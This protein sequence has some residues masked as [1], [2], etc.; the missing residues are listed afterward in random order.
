MAKIKSYVDLYT[1]TKLQLQD[2][3][4]GT[5]TVTIIAPTLAQDWALTL[6]PDDGTSGQYL[7]TDGSGVTTWQTISGVQDSPLDLKNYSIATS[8]SSNALTIALKDKAGSDPS[9]GSPVNIAV[10]SATATSG[11]YNIR[12]VTGALSL[13]ISSGSTLG[14]IDGK[15]AYIYVYVLDN[16]G[17]LELVAS[18]TRYD[19][20]SIQTTTAE[21]GSGAADS[22]TG[23]YSTSAR[24]NVPV[25]F[26]GR[27]ASVQTTAGTWAAQMQEVSIASQAANTDTYGRLNFVPASGAF[28]T[29]TNSEF[30]G[31]RRGRMLK[32]NGS[33]KCGTVAGGDIVIQLPP[34]MTIN[35]S[36]VSATYDTSL[37]W[38]F[39]HFG[40][41]AAVFGGL[42]GTVFY[43][44]SLADTGKIR[45]STNTNGGQLGT[46]LDQTGSGAFTSSDVIDLNF[47]IPI[48]EWST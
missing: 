20:R 36:A 32:V 2:P 21:G 13:V 48:N 26:I 27:L 40:S 44:L 12:S 14:H 10:R 16:A 46:Y 11:T 9:S 8:V 30:Y 25:R 19:D 28:G 43:D 6:P 22:I 35:T 39:R 24:S 5:N 7:Q 31:T 47:E 18:S 23:L 42:S 15:F 34:G 41:G 37:G 45:L 4:A 33:F 29:V 17:T 38:F 3:G 1:T